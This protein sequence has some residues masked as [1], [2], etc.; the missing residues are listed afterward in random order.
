MTTRTHHACNPIRLDGSRTYFLTHAQLIGAN[1]EAIRLGFPRT[2]A[3]AKVAELPADG[4][5]PVLAAWEHTSG[6][7]FENIRLL[8]FVGQHPNDLHCVFLDVHP[9]VW[10]EIKQNWAPVQRWQ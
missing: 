6:E 1:K 3:A 2:L 10:E 5:F 9:L 7:G 8:L 4:K